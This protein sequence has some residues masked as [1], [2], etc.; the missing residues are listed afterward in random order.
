MLVSQTYILYASVGLMMSVGSSLLD[1]YI[2]GRKLSPILTCPPEQ[3]YVSNVYLKH[4]FHMFHSRCVSAEVDWI[5]IFMG[6]RG[7]GLSRGGGG[8]VIQIARHQS[9]IIFTIVVLSV[10]IIFIKRQK[11]NKNQTLNKRKMKCKGIYFIS[12]HL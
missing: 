5:N 12:G 2:Y 10:I 11:G 1:K 9:N 7:A 3:I 6:G 8:R 4:T